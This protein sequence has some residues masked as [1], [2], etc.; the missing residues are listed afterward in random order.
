M[1]HHAAMKELTKPEARAVATALVRQGVPTPAVL[2][3]LKEQGMPEGMLTYSAVK[4]MRYRDLRAPRQLLD[5]TRSGSGL[6]PWSMPQEDNQHHWAACLR[7]MHP[8]RK[9]PIPER[10]IR[11]IASLRA[12]LAENDRVINYDPGHDPH[13]HMVPRRWK[14]DPISGIRIPV[15]TG[16]IRNPFIDDEGNPR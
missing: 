3:R 8:D 10:Y 14:A 5:H 12:R 16:I 1:C 9:A 11:A 13:W 15:D 7:F 6:I 4:D 2:E